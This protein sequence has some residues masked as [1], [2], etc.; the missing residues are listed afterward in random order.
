MWLIGTARIIV[1]QIQDENK[2]IIARLQPLN[3]GT[4]KQIFGYESEITKVRGYVVGETNLNLIKGYARDGAVHALYENAIDHGD[5]YV[6][7]VGTSRLNLICQT[8][9]P[10]EDIHET[11]WEVDVELY[12]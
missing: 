4:I 5:Y 12:T 11:V 1:T 3:G 10:L 9:D 2:Q 7:S 6:A 8:I